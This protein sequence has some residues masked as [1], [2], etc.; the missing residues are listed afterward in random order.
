M[1]N[2]AAL[3]HANAASGARAWASILCLVIGVA[4]G[5]VVHLATD[6]GPAASPY[7]AIP[8][9]DEPQV[10]HDVAAAILADDARTLSTQLS[11]DV[12]KQ[13]GDALTPLADVRSV[14]F[15]GA[16]EDQGRVLS[17]YIAHG[18]SGQGQDLIV[19]FVLQVRADQVVGVN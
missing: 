10:A 12:L 2:A 1:S 5:V 14:K 16:V 7:P 8:K 19:G 3:A 9:S 15:V 18:K 13:L 17:A 11:A 6:Q 4:L